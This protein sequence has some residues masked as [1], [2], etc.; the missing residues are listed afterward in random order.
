MKIQEL[1]EQPEMMGLDPVQQVEDQIKAKEEQKRSLDKEIADLRASL[2]K[3]Q[4]QARQ[5][6]ATATQQQQAAQQQR[7]ASAAPNMPTMPTPPA[8]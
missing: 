5:Q 6:T 4:Q 1:L 8:A 3:L 2:P 7:M